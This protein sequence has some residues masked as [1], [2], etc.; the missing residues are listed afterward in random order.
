M[1][2]FSN[3]QTSAREGGTKFL[4]RGGSQS[5]GQSVSQSVSQSGRQSGTTPIKLLVGAKTPEELEQGEH[6]EPKF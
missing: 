3:S 6:S 1:R 5:V 2:S 4:T